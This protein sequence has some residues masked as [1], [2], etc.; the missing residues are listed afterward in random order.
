MLDL[1]TPAGRR[2]AQRLR[3]ELIIWL[4]T[5]NAAGQPQSSPVWFLWDGES[6]LVYSKPKTPKLR[7]LDVNPRV[8]LHLDGNGRGGDV[9]VIEGSAVYDTEVSGADGV[10]AY[11]EK[12]GERIAAN[13]WTPASFAA[14]YSEALRITPRSSRVW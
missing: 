13:G 12:Y 3:D 4:T 2:A 11:V 10:P 8:G 7:N 6:F 1:T 14:D 5:V 9:V